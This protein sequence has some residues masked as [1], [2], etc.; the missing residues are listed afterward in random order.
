M[1]EIFFL[2]Y[3]SVSTSDI[4]STD[5]ADELRAILDV[6]RVNNAA[7]DV[8]GA[9]VLADGH[10]VQYLEGDTAKVQSLYAKIKQDAR[11]ERCKLLASGFKADRSFSAWSMAY[12]GT[13]TE[14][15]NELA[16]VL[17]SADTLPMTEAG[18]IVRSYLLSHLKAAAGQS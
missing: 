16:G 18:D 8:T 7:L 10:F 4:S 15:P 13:I 5:F 2:C 3:S 1:S 9:L 11:H 6:C 14:I 17:N 12:G